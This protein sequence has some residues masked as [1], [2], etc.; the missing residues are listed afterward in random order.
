VE[1]IQSELE[2]I[3]LP[4]GVHFDWFPLSGAGGRVSSQLAVIHFKGQC[5]TEDLRTEWGYPGPLGRTH[6]SNGE[7]LPFID[8]NCEGVRLLYSG[9]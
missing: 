9:I 4:A 7:I 8:V 1:A 2:D 3:M 5:D 6:V